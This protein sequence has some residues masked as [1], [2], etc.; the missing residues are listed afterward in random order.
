MTT[1]LF[2]GSFNPFTRG[3]LSIAQ[4]AAGIFDRLIIAVG[5]N[6]SKSSPA[7][8]DELICK[9]KEAVKD[10]HNVEVISY[11]G[12]TV[13]VCRQL[14]AG[15][16]VRGLRNSSDFNYEQQLAEVNRKI[17]GIETIFLNS[18]PELACIS[19]SM[20]RE[21]SGFGVDVTEFLP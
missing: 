15:V 19:S 14:G 20:V 2:P 11:S 5:V 9:I 8:I 3:H 18:T 1:A 12:L 21:L 6:I 13:D 7:Q 16:I 17:S 4:R 10:I